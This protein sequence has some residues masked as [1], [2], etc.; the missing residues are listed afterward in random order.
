ME[1][2]G[3]QWIV[4]IPFCIFSPIFETDP[5]GGFYL[6]REQDPPSQVEYFVYSIRRR[7][8]KT[9]GG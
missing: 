1:V 4:S 8:T 5:D 9:L 2:N 6:K 3:G 7:K